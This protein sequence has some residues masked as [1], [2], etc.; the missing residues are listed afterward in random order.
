MMKII[1]SFYKEAHEA[2]R[3]KLQHY[4]ADGSWICLTSDG[5]SASNSDSYLRVTAHWTN[6]VWITYGI[7]LKFTQMLPLH[8]GKAYSKALI[9]TCKCFGIHNYILSITTDNHV[10]ND[11]MYDR[12]EKYTFKS[13]EQGFEFK[14]LLAIFKAENGHIRCLAHS[15]NLS[16]Q[17]IL[18]TLK[19]IAE[20]HV[21]VLY[22]NTK[23]VGKATYASAIGKARRIIVRYRRSSL[24]RAAL[25]RQCAAH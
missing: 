22:N 1:L 18:S 9:A 6:T 15:I 12:F 4:I 7:L 25:A 14:L 2:V 10:V 13:A 24:M 20:K 17:A 19:S 3:I 5:W 8:T 23:F 21:S 16:A 11:G